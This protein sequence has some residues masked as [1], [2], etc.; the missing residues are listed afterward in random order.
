MTTTACVPAEEERCKAKR[1]A[2]EPHIYNRK[3]KKKKKKKK[4]GF[5][6][7]K[8]QVKLLRQASSLRLV[9]SF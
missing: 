2:R 3:K 7:A 9:T 8:H 5:F 6:S 4:D 1:G